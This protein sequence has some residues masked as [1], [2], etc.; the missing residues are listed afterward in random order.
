MIPKIIHYCWFGGRPKPRL[1]R[2]CIAS[3]KRYCPGWQIIEWNEQ[4]FD[5][6]RNGYT[7]ICM[8]KGQY[9]FLSDYVRL[10]VVEAWGGVYL[11]TD[12]ELLGPLEDL[13]TEDAF[14]GFET[15]RQVATGLGFGS[16]AHGT[17]VTA[18]LR[19]YD[20]LLDGSSGTRMCPALNTAALEALGL[21]PDGSRQRV[22]EA[23]ILPPEYLNPMDSATGRIRRTENTR[24]IHHYAASWL[25]RGKR[26]RLFVTRPL[27]RLFG[28]ECLRWLTGRNGS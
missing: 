9:A 19:A 22:A 13:L 8:E 6:A 28:K 7:R 2:T 23:L 16:V 10:A 21:V 3:W 18:M 4:N 17:A 26:L 11:D 25:S 5:P 24:A 1:V 27:H 12:V 15:D 20:P 14:F